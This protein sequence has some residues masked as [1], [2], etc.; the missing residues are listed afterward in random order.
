MVRLA[1]HSFLIPC[2][3][4]AA[5][6]VAAHCNRNR[7]NGGHEKTYHDHHK[8]DIIM[9]RIRYHWS[10]P[11]SMWT[12]TNRNAPLP[13]T[14][15]NRSEHVFSEIHRAI[16]ANFIYKSFWT[17]SSTIIYFEEYSK[18]GFS[19]KSTWVKVCRAEILRFVQPRIQ[20]GHGGAHAQGALTCWNLSKISTF[21]K[22]PPIAT[23]FLCP[24]IIRSMVK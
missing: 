3:A 17:R 7:N 21:S 4:R 2:V 6:S 16:S 15:T 9:G 12:G 5:V 18:P 1:I 19:Y 24:I 10:S 14:C 11:A 22:R 13:L 20:G 23:P 8:N